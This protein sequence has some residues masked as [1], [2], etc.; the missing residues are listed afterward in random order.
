[1]KW[2]HLCKFDI[3][4]PYP[5]MLCDRQSSKGPVKCP[6]CSGHLGLVHQEFTVVKPY[7]WHLEDLNLNNFKHF[8]AA[9]EICKITC[10]HAW[11]MI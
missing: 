7:P 1:M 9:T 6:P 11:H 10:I 5:V 2:V 3:E 4:W 8:N